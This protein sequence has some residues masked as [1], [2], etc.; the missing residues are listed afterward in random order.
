MCIFNLFQFVIYLFLGIFYLYCYERAMTQW[1]S[2]HK[3]I[4]TVCIVRY[5]LFGWRD[6]TLYNKIQSNHKYL[7]V[8]LLRRLYLLGR[9]FVLNT[10]NLNFPKA[11]YEFLLLLI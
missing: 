10:E 3:E 5:T 4:L 11:C 7:L 1:V 8:T 9:F 6:F 2:Y